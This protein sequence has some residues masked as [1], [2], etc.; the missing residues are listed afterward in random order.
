[1]EKWTLLH[2]PLLCFEPRTCPAEVFVIVA[3]GALCTLEDFKKN[4]K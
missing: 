1:M 3:F 2:H 4:V